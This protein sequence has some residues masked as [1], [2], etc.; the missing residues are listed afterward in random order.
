[1]TGLLVAVVLALV[2][3]HAPPSSPGD[4]GSA[5]RGVPVLAFVADVGTHRLATVAVGWDTLAA[6]VDNHM[7]ARTFQDQVGEL[8]VSLATGDQQPGDTFA[9]RFGSGHVDYM[10]SIVAP[11]SLAGFVRT[12]ATRALLR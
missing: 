10:T 9:L 4:G 6:V 1:M 8:D 3:V 2:P 11:R 7:Y 5:G 12:T